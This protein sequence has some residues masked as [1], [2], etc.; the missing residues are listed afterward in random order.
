M[1]FC[2]TL[3]TE[4]PREARLKYILQRQQTKTR[5]KTLKLKPSWNKNFY[6]KHLTILLLTINFKINTY[7]EKFIRVQKHN[8][9]ALFLDVHFIICSL[10][11]ECSP[12]M[13]SFFKP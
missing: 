6:T 4:R 7:Y 12:V 3:L 8:I 2:N 10:L 9:G 5:R 13:K 1:T 11:N